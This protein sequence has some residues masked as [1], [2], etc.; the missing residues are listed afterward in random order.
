MTIDAALCLRTF[1]E[2]DGTSHRYF[3][4]TELAAQGL[5]GV[6]RLP[7]VIRLL[8]ESAL[9]NCNGNQVLHDHVEALARWQAQAPRLGEIPFVVGRVLLQDF[10]GVPLLTDLAAM[11][12]EAVRRGADPQR[13]QPLIPVHLVIDHSVQTVYS[14][15][16]GAVERNQQLEVQQNHERYSF[17]KWGTQAFDTFKVVP[18]GRGICHQINLEYLAHGVVE[19]D[20]VVFPDTLVGTDSHTTMVNGIGVLGWGVGGIEAEAAMLG[21]PL[22]LLM[23]DVVGV[24]LSGSLRS[25]VTATDAVLHITQRLRATGVVQV[26]GIFGR[27]RRLAER[28]RPRDHR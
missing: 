2:P 27:R 18:P 24:C 5:P 28:H 22:Y 20:G 23:P 16:A 17:L 21:Q 6:A 14:G 15:E 25:G 1:S 11:R 13:I 4:L 10:T 19:K 26:G 8:L 12:S 7:V 9:R 3:S